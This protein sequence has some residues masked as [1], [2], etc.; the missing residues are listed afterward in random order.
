MA[1][2]CGTTCQFT[3]SFLPLIGGV[4]SGVLAFT[5]VMTFRI[6]EG[7]VDFELGSSV[8]IKGATG[9]ILMWCICFLTISYGLYLLGLGDAAKATPT[10]NYRSCSVLKAM[11]GSCVL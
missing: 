4:F 7:P 11:T 10:T 9:P 5:L 1:Y 6:H 3:P 2:A 8:K